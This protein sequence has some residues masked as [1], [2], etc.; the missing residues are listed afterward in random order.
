MPSILFVLSI[1]AMAVFSTF[2][3]VL[4]I[5]LAVFVFA[6]LY[7]KLLIKIMGA[8]PIF[9]RVTGLK[10]PVLVTYIILALV[11]F[12]FVYALAWS[13][14]GISIPTNS[15]G[16][17]YDVCALTSGV[18]YKEEW[19]KKTCLDSSGNQLQEP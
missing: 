3:V 19:D 18:S 5:L 4:V 12:V 8:K 15:Y 10:R 1:F 13:E 2:G 9:H 7:S 17:R 6:P 14:Y 11:N 16:L